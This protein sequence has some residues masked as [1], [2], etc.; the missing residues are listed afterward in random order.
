MKTALIL[1]FADGLA[2][3]LDKAFAFTPYD[4]TLFGV[5]EAVQH[6]KCSHLVAIDK[7]NIPKWL[8]GYPITVHTA[9]PGGIRMD[10]WSEHVDCYWPKLGTNGSSGWLAAKI[11]VKLGFDKVIMCGC[12]IDNSKHFTPNEKDNWRKNPKQAP[13]CRSAIEAEAGPYKDKIF[14]M[15][16]WTM[17]FF[18]PPYIE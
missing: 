15:S 9:R 11:A 10:K 14:S 2:D 1:G 5:N 17:E 13:T 3:D 16:G 7:I 12:P 6:Y 4:V 18:G 8:P